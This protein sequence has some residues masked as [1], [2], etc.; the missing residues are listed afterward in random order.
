VNRPA[1][2]AFLSIV[3]WPEGW[4]QDRCARVLVECAGFDAYGAGLAARRGTPQVAGLVDVDRAAGILERLSGAGVTA[5]AP[6]ESELGGL[7]TV[8]VKDLRR[9]EGAPEAMYVVEPWRR[10]DALALKTS[11]IALLV[12]GT[13]DRQRRRSRADT[14]EPGLAGAGAVMIA[15]AAG[16]MAY[17]AAGAGSVTTTSGR[18][19]EVLD[20]F[21]R[22]G[23]RL[24]IDG[25]KFGFGVLGR[26]RAL[27]DREN[28]DRLALRLARE[29]PR[30]LLDMGFGN[31]RCPPHLL[32]TTGRSGGTETVRVTDETPIFEFYSAWA[33]LMHRR[34]IA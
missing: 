32:R 21:T 12:R 23:L 31:F 18:G 25:D 8:A 34:W 7:V 27:T 2:R 15:G 20:I 16:A 9:A 1:E 17:A 11:E 4:D 14:S 22:E 29:A 13:I 24:R 33:W 3:Q 5:F 19:T 26:E 30:A 28:T 10:H 6:S